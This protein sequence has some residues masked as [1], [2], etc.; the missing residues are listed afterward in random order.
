MTSLTLEVFRWSE[1]SHDTIVAVANA[2]LQLT[3]FH[4][5]SRSCKDPSSPDIHEEAKR[6]FNVAE[7]G[8]GVHCMGTQRTEVL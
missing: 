1:A 8:D 2:A 6:M 3:S 7:L 4:H 5:C